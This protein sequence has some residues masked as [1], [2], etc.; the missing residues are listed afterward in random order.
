MKLNVY[1]DILKLVKELVSNLLGRTG[2][3]KKTD[4][5]FELCLSLVIFIEII[6]KPCK[7]FDHVRSW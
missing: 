5:L 6:S 3:E 1:L 2:L 7:Y 4:S